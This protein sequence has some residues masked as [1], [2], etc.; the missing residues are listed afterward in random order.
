MFKYRNFNRGRMKLESFGIFA[1]PETT[2]LFKQ[3]AVSSEKQITI[4]I[5]DID[6]KV[7]LK[8]E[9][10]VNPYEKLENSFFNGEKIICKFRFADDVVEGPG[11][12]TSV[13]IQ[14]KDG[15]VCIERI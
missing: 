7:K 10:G 12:S 14:L 6:F 1:E 3:R 4:S 15:F 9:E 2:C 5:N 11:S 13:T 8:L